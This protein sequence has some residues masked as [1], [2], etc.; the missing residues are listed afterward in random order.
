[1][2]IYDFRTYL[3][4]RTKASN[5][6]AKWRLIMFLFGGIPNAVA[7]VSPEKEGSRTIKPPCT[8]LSVY[9]NGKRCEYH[10]IVLSFS[11]I[12]FKLSAYS[13]RSIDLAQ[14]IKRLFVHTI[15]SL[16]SLSD[17]NLRNANPCLSYFSIRNT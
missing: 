3:A 6:V 2:N 14:R 5:S 12:P 17:C 9:A 13:P 8:P 16:S 7:I 11:I 4:G 10:R 1:M 15:G